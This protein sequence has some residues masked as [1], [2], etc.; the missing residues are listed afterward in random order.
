VRGD[1]IGRTLGYPTANLRLHEEKLLPADGIYAVRAG[2]GD[3]PVTRPAAMSIGMRP[4]F[5][6]KER[7]LEVHLLDWSGDLVGEEVVVELADWLRPEERFETPE[8]LVAAMGRDVAET[9]RRL[10]AQGL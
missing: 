3:E 9:R 5:D 10:A 2:I 7:T 4:T 1:G 8:S 6:G